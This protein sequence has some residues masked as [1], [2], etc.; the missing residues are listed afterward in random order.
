METPGLIS[1]C[2]IQ[3]RISTESL[4]ASRQHRSSAGVG[5][6]SHVSVQQDA[7]SEDAVTQEPPLALRPLPAGQAS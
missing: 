5:S 2:P 3:G 6:G 4:L 7:E 1:K